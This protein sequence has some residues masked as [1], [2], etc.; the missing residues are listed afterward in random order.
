MPAWRGPQ[1]DVDGAG[2]TS[3]EEAPKEEAPKSIATKRQ[4]SRKKA[5]LTALALTGVVTAACKA[6]KVDRATFY[7]WREQDPVFAAQCD[8]AFQSALDLIEMRAMTMAAAGDGPMIRFLLS[9]RRPE[10]YG[11]KSRD[12]GED[13]EPPENALPPVFIFKFAGRPE[14]AEEREEPLTIDA[15]SRTVDALPARVPSEDEGAPG[16]EEGEDEN[17]EEEQDGRRY[18]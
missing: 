6:A 3:P 5:V 18:D 10:V 7:R 9:R 2:V 15:T 4:P 12:K 11:D 13:E 1:A 16:E 14:E 17:E 8:D